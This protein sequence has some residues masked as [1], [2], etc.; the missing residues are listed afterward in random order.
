MKSKRW[1]KR[2][3][4]LSLGTL[5]G[6]L[7]AEGLLRA[8]WLDNNIQWHIWPPNL[9]QRF[10][11]A[12]EILVGV[13]DTSSFTTN[14]HGFRGDE[15]LADATQ[16]LCLG[17]S[18][19][20]CLYLDD[21]EAWP[22]LLQKLLNQQGGKRIQIMNG[23]R[24]GHGLPHHLLQLEKILPQEPSIKKVIILAG[25]NDFLRRLSTNSDFNR[26]AYLE[27][28]VEKA[29]LVRPPSTYEKW[30]KKTALWH[31][32]RQNWQRIQLEKRK[33]EVQDPSG[34]AMKGWREK[35]AN[36]P[37]PFS[38]L[39]NL[40]ASIADYQSYI[41]QIDSVCL[42]H[43]IELVWIAQPVLWRDSMDT[44]FESLLWS[45]ALLQQGEEKHYFKP[46][47]LYAGMT[48]FNEVLD[49]TAA[50]LN[51]QIIR[52]DT[53]LPPDTTVFY[54]DMHFNESGAVRV[55]K[56]LSEKL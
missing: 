4:M 24:A 33:S 38:A 36:A 35:R 44:F 13:N 3:G 27:G 30:Y 50:Q 39:G 34:L 49:Q 52:M 14:S 21:E 23:G 26:A 45:G 42:H 1:L 51:R 10:Y 18:T 9:N 6:L 15:Y 55:A 37:R 29:F 20:E 12:P 7:L 11:P 22:R 17:G 43:Q 2:I 8:F 28:L 41:R 32:L 31:I 16:I 56:L 54:D 19:T 48:A 53:M 46:S 5:L 47:A 40:D 25:A